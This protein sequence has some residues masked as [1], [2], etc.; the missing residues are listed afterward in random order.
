MK[1]Y[2]SQSPPLSELKSFWKSIMQLYDLLISDPI[3]IGY[4]GFHILIF[5]SPNR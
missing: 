3:E 2:F 5:T 1:T 4:A